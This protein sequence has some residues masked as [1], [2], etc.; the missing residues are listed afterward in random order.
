MAWIRIFET[1]EE[2]GRGK[3]VLEEGGI[4]AWV[5]ED[6]FNGIPIQNFR[7]R[8]RF[9]LLVN[10]SDYYRAAAFLAEKLRRSRIKK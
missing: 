6:K 5:S 9:R 8:A 4:T 10:D 7:V 3:K 1:K 2:A